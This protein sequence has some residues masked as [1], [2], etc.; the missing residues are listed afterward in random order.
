[1]IYEPVLHNLPGVLTRELPDRAV[2]CGSASKAYAM[3]GW[4]CGWAIGPEEVIAASGALQS[5]Q[6]SNVC[7]ITQ[8]AVVAALTGSQQCVTEM[9]EEYR[10]RRDRVWEWL[11]ADPRITCVKPAGAFYLFIDISELLSPKGVRTSS[12]FADRLIEEARVVTTAGEAFDA[13]G[14]LRISYANSLERLEE[15]VNRISAFVKTLEG[16]AVTT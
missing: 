11:T 1:L 15:A 12:Q 4:R 9:L 5:H 2:V 13:P 3:T 8:R 6:T 10:T 7:S 14:F 16:E